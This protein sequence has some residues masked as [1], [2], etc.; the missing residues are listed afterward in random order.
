[1]P[2]VNPHPEPSM[3]TAAEAVEKALQSAPNALPERAMSVTRDDSETLSPAILRRLWTRF[4]AIY[5]HRW[6]S[7]YGESCEDA[8]GNLTVAGDTW[9]RGLIDVPPPRI[10]EGLQVCVRSSDPWPPTLPAFRAMCVPVEPAS[11]A[12]RTYLGSPAV[13]RHLTAIESERSRQT[14]MRELAKM[15][16]DFGIELA[17][18]PEASGP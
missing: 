16:A 6:S 9:A 14:A 7:A 11:D 18:N 17:Q 12:P 10:A 3:K 8:D 2:Q 13:R 4:T 5:G 1:M 15:C